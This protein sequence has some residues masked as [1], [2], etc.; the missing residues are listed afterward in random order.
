MELD[1]APERQ[2]QSLSRGRRRL[3]DS[4]HTIQY[5]IVS[6]LSCFRGLQPVT[7]E[8]TIQGCSEGSIVF[9]GRHSKFEI[10]T[11]GWHLENRDS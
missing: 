11:Q 1:R 7:W 3:A 10:V 6:S 2:T 4:S 8:I 9:P 5:C